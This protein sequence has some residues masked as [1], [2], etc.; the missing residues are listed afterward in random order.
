MQ[1]GGELPRVK[2]ANVVSLHMRESRVIILLSILEQGY[3]QLANPN[4]WTGQQK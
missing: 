3:T 2:E 4:Y 1:D